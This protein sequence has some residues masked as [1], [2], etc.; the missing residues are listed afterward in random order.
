LNPF[1]FAGMHNPEVTVYVY[2][3]KHGIISV[4]TANSIVITNVKRKPNYLFV[5]IT[6]K[7]L[8][9]PKLIFSFKNNNQVAFTHKYT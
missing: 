9:P 1:W 5:T 7:V 2:G 3:K 8:L 4:A 6:L